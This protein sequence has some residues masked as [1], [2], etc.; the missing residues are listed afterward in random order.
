[1]VFLKQKEFHLDY[2]IRTRSLVNLNNTL[3]MEQQYLDTALLL[4][5]NIILLKLETIIRLA[6]LDKVISL[7]A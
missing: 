3:I 7:S 1:M 6:L 4:L 2:T 5:V